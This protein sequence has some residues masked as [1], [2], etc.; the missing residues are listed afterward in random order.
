VLVVIALILWGIPALLSWV[1]RLVRWPARAETVKHVTW[2]PISWTLSAFVR[3]LF[4]APPPL[5]GPELSRLSVIW[6]VLGLAFILLI[7][8]PS[9][10]GTV[11]A[12]TKAFYGVIGPSTDQQETQ[13]VVAVYSDK[14]FVAHVEGRTIRWVEMRNLSDLKDVEVQQ[15]EIGRLHW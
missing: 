3:P 2:R 6:A 7:T 5:R 8:V 13:A 11:L 15:K 9:S 1:F 12:H 10:M 4:G 14:V